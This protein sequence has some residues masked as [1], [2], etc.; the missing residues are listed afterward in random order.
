MGRGKHRDSARVQRSILKRPSAANRGRRIAYVNGRPVVSNASSRPLGLVADAAGRPASRPIRILNG[1]A[2]P[3]PLKGGKADEG[4]GSA[5]AEPSNTKNTY[6]LTSGS[7]MLDQFE[8]WY[9]G[10]AYAFLFKYCTGMPDMPEWSK[11]PRYRRPESAP[12]I[13]TSLWVR[14]MSRRVEAQFARD[15]GFGYASWNFL[16]RSAINLSRT[17]YSL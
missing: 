10:V 16:F 2:V 12:R 8:P 11:H 4:K 1:K 15:W 7:A 13:P 3:A 14:V 9:F 6:V 5:A 17:L